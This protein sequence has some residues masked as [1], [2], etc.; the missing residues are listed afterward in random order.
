[1]SVTVALTTPNHY[2]RYLDALGTLEL[3][4]VGPEGSRGFS[5]RPILSERT[6][7]VRRSCRRATAAVGQQ[8]RKELMTTW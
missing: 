3:S 8:E 1:L 7:V 4:P 6:A 2:D 5:Q